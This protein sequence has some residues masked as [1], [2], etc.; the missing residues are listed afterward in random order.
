MERLSFSYDGVSISYVTVYPV[1][2]ERPEERA[3]SKGKNGENR[4]F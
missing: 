1:A 3:V 2:T 4:S